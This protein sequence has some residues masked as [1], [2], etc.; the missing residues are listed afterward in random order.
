MNKISAC[1]VVKNEE[2]LIERCLLSLVSVVDEIIVVHDGECLDQTINICKK[3]GAQIIIAPASNNCNPHRPLSFEKGSS[4]WILQIDADEF[5]SSDLQLNIKS[6]VEDNEVS[7]FEFLWPIWN[8]GRYV[9]K[10][11]PY[12]RCLF[13]KKD[14]SFLGLPNF[15]PEIR[16]LVKREKILLEHRP[17]NDNFSLKVF[18]KKLVPKAE[19]QARAYLSDFSEVRK[20]NYKLSEWPLNVKLRVRF[21]LILMPFEFLITVYKNLISGA[22]R[23]GWFGLRVALMFGIYRV[24]VNYYIFKIKYCKIK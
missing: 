5:L 24:I 8:N 2:K 11:W 17:L 4:E 16:G 9:T 3:Y 20:F 18:S 14:V 12:K 10:N 1:I 15:V 23:E 6:L 7:A 22:W 21:P 13:R 19:L